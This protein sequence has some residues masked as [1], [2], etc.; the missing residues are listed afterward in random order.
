MKLA[1]TVVLVLCGFVISIGGN[2]YCDIVLSREYNPVTGERTRA[3][4]VEP[5]KENKN[6]GCVHFKKKFFATKRDKKVCI[7]CKHFRE[8]DWP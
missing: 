3:I 5:E 4:Y 8:I 6:N 1:N 7:D 2:V